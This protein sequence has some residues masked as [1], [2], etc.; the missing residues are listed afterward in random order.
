MCG[1][2]T[3]EGRGERQGS[4]VRGQGSEIRDQG[5]EIRGHGYRLSEWVGEDSGV[6]TRHRRPGFSERQRR[7]CFHSKMPQTG[8]L[9]A[10]SWQKGSASWS[11][12]GGFPGFLFTDWYT[13][14]VDQAVYFVAL[15]L[16][17]SPQEA[18][19]SEG[20]EGGAAV[21]F[22]FVRLSFAPAPSSFALLK[23]IVRPGRVILGKHLRSR[24]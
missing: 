20:G 23:T 12:I 2:I 4:G 9:F 6:P 16:I 21:S 3:W 13:G 22:P 7:R 14:Y 17:A 10:Q 24:E 11:A 1:G 19:F 8:P 5:S 18:G 15:A